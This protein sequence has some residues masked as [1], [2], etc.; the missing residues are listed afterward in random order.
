MSVAVDVYVD[1][2]GDNGAVDD[3][4]EFDVDSDTGGYVTA[5]DDDV[6]DDARLC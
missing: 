4:V 1:G 5:D 2:Y 3:D 6:N